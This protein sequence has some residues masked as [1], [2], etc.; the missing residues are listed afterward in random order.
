MPEW[1]GFTLGVSVC[2]YVGAKES[3]GP[4]ASEAHTVPLNHAS[5]SFGFFYMLCFNGAARGK[6]ILLG[7]T[8]SKIIKIIFCIIIMRL[9]LFKCIVT[10]VDESK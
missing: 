10:L 9:A 2:V 3:S 6:K 8:S 4:Q 7:K 5:S 1:R